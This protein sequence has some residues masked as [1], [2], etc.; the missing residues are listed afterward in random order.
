MKKIASIILMLIIFSIKSF[1]Q[2]SNVIFF[3]QQGEVFHVYLNGVLQNEQAT[4]NLKIE[5]LPSNQYKA[6]I[7]FS[8]TSLW[9]VTKSIYLKEYTETTFNIRKKEETAVGNKMKSLGN[10][11]SRDLN[12]KQPE[13]EREEIYVMRWFTEKALPMPQSTVVIY[14]TTT[15]TSIST[16]NA[17]NA[18]IETTETSTTTVTTTASPAYTD[19][20]S[21]KAN[22]MGMDFDMSVSDNANVQSSTVTTQTVT[23]TGG[24]VAGNDVVIVDAGCMPMSQMEFASAVRSVEEKD[25]EDSRKTM[26]KQI[27][28][29]N[30]LYAA[31]VKQLMQSMEFESTRL[32]IAKFAYDKTLDQNKYYM[33]NDAFDFESSIDDLNKYISKKGRM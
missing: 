3:S 6:R 16:Q 30:C 2:K 1:S 19:Q 10:S 23:T 17:N 20:V 15:P 31:Q 32:E 22:M 33:V 28:D 24:T 8:D 18:R 4:N 12:M 21:V 13:K 27:I 7:V 5:D 25:F 26:A 14:Q 29:G 11:I 9:Q